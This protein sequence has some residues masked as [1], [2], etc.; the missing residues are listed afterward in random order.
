M[1][2]IAGWI[3][4]LATAFAAAITASNCGAR[5]TGWRFVVFLVGFICWCMA[6]VT[7]DQPN[8]FWATGFL[9]LV[10][11]LGVWR[12]LGRQA[13]YERDGQR[14]SDRSAR[15]ASSTLVPLRSLVG[16]PV[17]ELDGS[18]SAPMHAPGPPGT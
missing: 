1:S 3:A 15:T 6:A 16:G 8:L 5:V 12:W 17:I 11:G 14:A 10:N 13:R 7:A 18:A 4:P 9:S 2:D